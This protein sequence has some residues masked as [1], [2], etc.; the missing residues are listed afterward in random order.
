MLNYICM[1]FQAMSWSIR[2]KVYWEK[3]IHLHGIFRAPPSLLPIMAYHLRFERNINL[4]LWSSHNM[5]PTRD[6]PNRAY[7]CILFIFQGSKRISSIL[8]R[9]DFVKNEK[10][11]MEEKRYSLYLII[12]R[13]AF[14]G[15]KIHYFISKPTIW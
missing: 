1:W 8:S 11:Y 10:L 14:K 12:W 9:L 4:W 3:T 15:A 6:S 2:L 13:L 7:K 5:R